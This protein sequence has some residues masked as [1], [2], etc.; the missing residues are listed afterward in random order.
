MLL[1]KIEPPE[2]PCPLKNNGY[3]ESKENPSKPFFLPACTL[4]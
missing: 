2:V 3:H 1:I 4:K